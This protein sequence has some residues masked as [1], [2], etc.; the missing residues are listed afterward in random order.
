VLSADGQTF[1]P[2]YGLEAAL[3]EPSALYYLAAA[4]VCDVRGQYRQGEM[5]PVELP[6]AAPIGSPT[7]AQPPAVE[8]VVDAPVPQRQGFDLWL[9]AIGGVCVVMIFGALFLRHRRHG[10]PVV[11]SSAYTFNKDGADHGNG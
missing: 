4:G 10:Q 11:V 3:P 6:Q 8:P 5:A 7:M 1:T 2:L 9:L